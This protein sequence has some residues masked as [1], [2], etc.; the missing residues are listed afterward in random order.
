MEYLSLEH[1][2]LEDLLDCHNDAFSEYSQPMQLTLD[3]F[4]AIN[5]SRGVSYIHSIGAF[6]NGTIVGFILNAIR[7]WNGKLTAYDCGTGVRMAN[8]SQKIGKTMFQ[9][10]LPLLQTH[11]V[12]QY[13]LEVIKTNTPALELYQKQGFHITRNFACVSASME[14]LR[15]LLNE[16][17][18]NFASSSAV[19]PIDTPNLDE[20]TQFNDFL[21][22]WQNSNDS[23][24]AGKDEFTT[25]GVFIGE[26]LVGYAIVNPK[27]G[28][29]S[30]LAVNP[31]YR[32]QGVGTKILHFLAT[33]L[34]A[35]GLHMLNIDENSQPMMQFVAK[36]AFQI[37]TEQYEMML[38][39]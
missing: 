17:T 5:I 8:Q 14:T 23:I 11:G 28:G 32:R 30:Q 7:L 15:P 36:F 33:H 19:C 6:E 1:I 3:R 20:F 39:I 37:F 29:I 4:R 25:Y 38:T 26:E 10:L 35:Q 24:Y 13:L 27:N 16:K 12:S 31:S 9:K 21:P 22:S 2:P 18:T 34:D